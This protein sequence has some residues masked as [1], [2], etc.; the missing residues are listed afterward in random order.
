[1]SSATRLATASISVSRHPGARLEG[2][3]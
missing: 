2:S 3:S 1:M